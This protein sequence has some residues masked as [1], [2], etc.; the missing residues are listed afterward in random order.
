MK[1][2]EYFSTWLNGKMPDL[3]KSTYEAYCIY[4]NC[5]INPYFDAL[6]KPLEDIVPMDIKNYVTR[7][8]TGG[9][10]DGKAG[11]LSKASVRKHLIGRAHV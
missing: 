10:M 8:R 4:V 5:H 11:G 9:R 3:E 7:K 1:A 6:G 2:S